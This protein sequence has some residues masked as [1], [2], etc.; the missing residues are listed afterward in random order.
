M[1]TA[2]KRINISLSRDVEKALERLAQRDHVPQATK[3]AD[4]LQL[5]LEFEEDQVWDK[6]AQRRDAAQAKFMSHERAWR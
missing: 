6:L 3:A 1:L 2:K 4:L 5:A